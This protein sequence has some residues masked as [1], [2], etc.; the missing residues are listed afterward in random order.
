[1]STLVDWKIAEV[2][3]YITMIHLYNLMFFVVMNLDTWN[4]LPPDIQ[5][6]FDEVSE[7]QVK[8]AGEI[9]DKN[10]V[11][12]AALVEKEYDME[13]IRLSPEEKARW[14]EIITQV[15]DEKVAEV[16]AKGLPAREMFDEILRLVEK[17]NKLYP[18]V[19]G[20]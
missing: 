8:K 1:M 15:R 20:M 2:T 18:H 6:I 11:E 19:A 3:S 4:A 12:D 13:I 5:K 14:E 7:E 9:W 16:E 10:E 17:Y